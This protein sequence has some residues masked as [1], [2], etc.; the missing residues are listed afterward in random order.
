MQN[1]VEV[2]VEPLQLQHRGGVAL[3]EV[4]ADGHGVGLLHT[5]LS[6]IPTQGQIQQG[7]S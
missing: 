5:Q 1:L 7:A 4:Q 6:Y 3:L 2:L